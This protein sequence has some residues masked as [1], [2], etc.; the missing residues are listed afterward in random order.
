MFREVM[1]VFRSF[2]YAIQG[3][4]SGFQERNMRVHGLAAALVLFLGLFFQLSV[5]EWLLV[6]VMIGLVLAAELLNTAVEE[7]CNLLRDELGLSYGAT[8]RARDLAAGAVL[9]CA[10][11]AAIVGAAVFFP[12]VWGLL[13]ILLI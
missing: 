11:T 12:H 13:W 7:I 6:V 1:K 5:W 3:I 10:L 4:V 2:G 9:I 8:R